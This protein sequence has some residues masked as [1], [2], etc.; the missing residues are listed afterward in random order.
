MIYTNMS[1]LIHVI[2]IETKIKAPGF[3]KLYDNDLNAYAEMILEIVYKHEASLVIC[4]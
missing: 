1:E 3:L 4:I 2:H